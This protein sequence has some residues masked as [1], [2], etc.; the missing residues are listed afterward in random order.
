MMISDLSYFEK[1]SENELILGGALLAV[2]ASVSVENGSTL[3]I[4]DVEVTN[5]GKVTKATGTGTAIA[6]GTNPLADV[7]VYYLGFD[8]VK[9]KVRSGSG[10]NYAFEALKI[11]AIDLPN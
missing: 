11:K 2:N 6:V 9:I 10:E 8:K 1:I 7:D 4:T 3:A 5:K